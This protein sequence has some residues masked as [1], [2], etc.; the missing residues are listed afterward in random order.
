MTA[1][2]NAHLI[3]SG[4]PEVDQIQPINWEQLSQGCVTLVG[5]IRYVPRTAPEIERRE[6]QRRLKNMTQQFAAHAKRL[7]R[8]HFAHV[9][10]YRADG[11]PVF[12]HEARR[13]AAQGHDLWLLLSYS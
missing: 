3:W 2:D 12:G 10:A 9:T 1:D 5:P 4:E 6:A 8:T 13:L 7:G 11:T